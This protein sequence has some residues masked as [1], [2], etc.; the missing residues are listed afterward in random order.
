MPVV[1][2]VS[3]GGL[4]AGLV[5]IAVCFLVYDFVFLPPYYTLY[6]D[7]DQDWIALGV[8]TV[9]MALVARVVAAANLAK[10]ESEPRATQLRRLF[11]VSELL[12]R[13]LPAP[14]LLE[15][16]VSSVKSRIQ[17]RRGLPP[18]PGADGRLQVVASTGAP[19]SEQEAEELSTEHRARQRGA[20]APGAGKLQ[21]VA[22]VATGKAVGL[23][24]V[25]GRAGPQGR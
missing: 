13:D 9:V 8:Y 18:P 22:L 10:A 25:R 17:P 23:L 4:R 24:A 2:G 21:A 15:T 19:L 11:E 20:C 5:A 3:V 12:V 16:I 6:V 14:E 7:R 1:A